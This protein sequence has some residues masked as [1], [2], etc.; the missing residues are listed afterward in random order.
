MGYYDK[1]REALVAIET[2]IEQSGTI[3]TARIQYIIA[4]KFGFS[5]NFVQKSLENLEKLGFI[6]INSDTVSWNI[7]KSP[8]E[9]KAEAEVDFFLAEQKHTPPE[10]AATREDPIPGEK[11]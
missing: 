2:L 1:K 5:T 6:L 11:K 4:K 3:K 7:P 8:Q 9:I 10:S